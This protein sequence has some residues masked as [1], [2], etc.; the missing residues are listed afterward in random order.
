M[1]YTTTFTLDM[2]ELLLE[3]D[4]SLQLV[5]R[6]TEPPFGVNFNCEKTAGELTY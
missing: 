2:I 1:K 6:V 5:F 4:S 3:A